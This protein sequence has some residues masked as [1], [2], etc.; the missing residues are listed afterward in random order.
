MA[1]HSYILRVIKLLL[2]GGSIQWE[3]FINAVLPSSYPHDDDDDD[4]GDDDDDDNDDDD[5]DGN[6]D[7]DDD[8]V[9][10]GLPM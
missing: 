1:I 10:S 7:D 4:H 5:D 2:S 9:N 6:D 3:G 8:D